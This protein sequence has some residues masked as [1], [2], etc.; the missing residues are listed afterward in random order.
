MKKIGLERRMEDG[1]K[2]EGMRAVEAERKRE[3]IERE[4]ES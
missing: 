1:W 4:R 3:R 2:S